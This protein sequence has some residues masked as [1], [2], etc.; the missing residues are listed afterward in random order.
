MKF[1]NIQ[2]TEDTIFKLL[3]A[4]GFTNITNHERNLSFLGM[5]VLH[6]MEVVYSKIHLFLNIGVRD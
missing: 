2:F 1:K 4:L 3:E 5:M 6:L